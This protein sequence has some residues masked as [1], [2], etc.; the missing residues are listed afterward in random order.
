L[1][2]SSSYDSFKRSSP[3][4]SYALRSISYC[5]K[6]I[7]SDVAPVAILRLSLCKASSFLAPNCG[8]C[9][10]DF[11]L[12]TLSRFSTKRSAFSVLL[13]PTKISRFVI[14]VVP[15]IWTS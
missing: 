5:A 7:G 11:V 6:L 15:A 8:I 12:T 4:E 10:E 13:F 3:F 1:T 14:L 9:S 2:V